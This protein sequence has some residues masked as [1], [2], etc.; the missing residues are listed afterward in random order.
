MTKKPR[1]EP[2]AP[3]AY[4]LNV[5]V[6]NLRCFSEAQTLDLSDGAGRPA[7]WTVILGDNGVGKTSMLQAIAM[8]GN[9]FPFRLDNH[10]VGWRALLR[11]E[12]V[13]FGV[14]AR[15]P[16][17]EISVRAQFS[18]IRA[19]LDSSETGLRCCGAL[20]WIEGQL[21]ISADRH[22]LTNW[23]CFGYGALRRPGPMARLSG[24]AAPNSETLFRDD[25]ELINAEEWLLQADYAAARQERMKQGVSARLALIKRMLVETLPDVEDVCIEEDPQDPASNPVVV[26][27]TVDGPRTLESLGLGYRTTISWLVDL[28]ARMVRRYPYSAN[29]IAEPAVALVDEIDLHLHPTWQRTLMS[30]L[31]ER[32]VNTQFIVTAHSP[33]VVQAATDANIV[34]LRREGDQVVIDQRPRSV[35]GWRVDQL[36]TSDLF[37]LPSARSARFDDLLTERRALLEKPRL[38]AEEVVRLRVLEGRMEEL[39]SGESPPDADALRVI[40]E[41]AEAIKRQGAAGS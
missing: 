28:A 16:E 11:D 22:E 36:L 39:P 12:R 8:L 38:T 26:F 40:R 1:A 25:G 18:T 30:F 17:H 29:P 2:Q 7:R 37:D 35:Q 15:D 24:A 9:R 19:L 20:Q 10:L 41:A 27:R 21:G 32:F 6:G 5:S 23:E 33:V 31:S 3:N 13:R 34:V 14:S 4:L